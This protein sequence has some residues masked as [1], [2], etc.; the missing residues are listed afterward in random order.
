MPPEEEQRLNRKGTEVV[1]AR[2]GWRGVFGRLGAN[3]FGLE[4]EEME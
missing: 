2:V 1:S 3:V 4:E